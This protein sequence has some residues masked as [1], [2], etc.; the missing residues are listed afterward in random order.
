MAICLAGEFDRKEALALIE[1]SWGRWKPG[2]VSG[3]ARLPGPAARFREGEHKR[4]KG[5]DSEFTMTGF[6]FGG[7]R[8]EDYVPLTMLDLILSNSQAGLIDL[9]L[10]QKQKILEGGSSLSFMGDYSWFVLYGTPGPRQTLGSV[11]RL[12]SRQ[13]DL[14]RRGRFDRRLLDGVIKF[15][16]IEQTQDLESNQIVNAFAECFSDG[17]SWSEYQGRLE[18]LKAFSADDLIRFVREK[19]HGNHVRVDKREGEDPSLEMMEKPD[20][21]PLK[22]DYDRQSDYF[23]RLRADNPGC[24]EP[25]F[26]DYKALLRHNDLGN[27]RE[28]S[29]CR[30]RKNDLFELT[31]IFP[32]GKSSSLLLPVAGDFFPYM[33]AEGLSPEALQKEA[34]LLGLDLSFQVD[35]DRTVFSVYGKEED[36]VSA[37][38]F[39]RNLIRTAWGSRRSYRKY[40]LGM[41]KR[42]RDAKLSK[43]LLLSGGLY[44]WG[45]YGE[46]SPFRDILSE[47]EL[48]SGDPEALVRELQRLFDLPHRIFYYGNRPPAEA[49]AL[50]TESHPGSGRP[51]RPRE[52]KQYREREGEEKV[53][54]THHDMLQAEIYRLA[55]QRPFDPSRLAG[56]QLFNEFFGAGLNSLFFQEIRE[57]R[58]LA[59]TAYSSISVPE[60][61]EQR[62]ILSSYL[63]TQADKLP[64][65]LAEMDRLFLSAPAKD[66]LFEEARTALLKSQASE[67]FTDSDIFWSWW[68]AR[69]LGLNPGF[70]KQVYRDLEAYTPADMER[71]F[72][73]SVI[74]VKSN[75]L[76]LGN[77]DDLD[78]KTLEKRGEFRELSPEEL[79]NY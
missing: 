22:I 67:R 40:I 12:L 53:F 23:G 44:S 42:R 13:L 63:G 8:S 56:I 48:R 24:P 66:R 52:H 43:K 33:G 37:L 72:T 71:F 50:L 11:H 7:V 51:A 36:F 75:V 38:K 45:L 15:L 4:L 78:M 77:R 70:R 69:E 64:D 57:A 2:A 59:Y 19:F 47:R 58:G 55:P 61:P 41:L 76:V 1:E 35:L 49:A 9:N 79:F 73:E 17:I 34:F 28:L 32:E 20:I 30:N 16:E 65:A 5:A 74:P 6:R 46:N 39:V 54:F 29:C 27:G 25:V 60:F 62:H 21:T 3:S 68:E 18:R 10:V 14:I 26:S 31:Y